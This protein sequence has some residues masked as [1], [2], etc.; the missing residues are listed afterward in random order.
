MPL[1]LLLFTHVFLQA[2]KRSGTLGPRVSWSQLLYFPALLT[3]QFNL[4]WWKPYF[5]THLN[6][7]W[8]ISHCSRFCTWEGHRVKQYGW[9]DSKGFI[10]RL[11]FNLSTLHIILKK[12]HCLYQRQG[13]QGWWCW[14]ARCRQH[15]VPHPCW[16]PAFHGSA[17]W[18]HFRHP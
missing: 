1:L 6:I 16:P 14:G 13:R 18:P 12:C 8:W 9:R 17:H 10:L 15:S 2:F 7:S 11:L 5:T 3:M 4:A